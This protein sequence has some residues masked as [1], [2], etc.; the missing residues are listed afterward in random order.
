MK[1]KL[2]GVAALAVLGA[3]SWSCTH[4]PVSPETAA[5]ANSREVAA[6]PAC[7]VPKDDGRAN[8]APCLTSPALK[9]ADP[10]PQLSLA[11]ISNGPETDG[12]DL[13]AN[14]EVY[15]FFR[16]HPKSETSPKFRCFRTTERNFASGGPAEFYNKKGVIVPAAVAVGAEGSANDGVLLDAS[17]R[18]VLDAR[19]KA[20]EG[21]E[22]KVKYFTGGTQQGRHFV[23]AGQISEARESEGFTEV[24][25][26]RVFWALGLPV[27]R[28]YNV[29]KVHCFGCGADPFNQKSAQAGATADFTDAAIELKFPGKTIAKTWPWR[30]VVDTYSRSWPLQARLDF[31]ALVLAAQ[32]ISYHNDLD[33]QNRVGCEQGQMADGTRVC[34]VPVALINDVGSTFGGPGGGFLFFGPGNSRGDL[35]DYTKAHRSPGRV[36]SNPG[37]CELIYPLGG[38]KRVSRAGVEAFKHRLAGFNQD[39]ARAIFTAAKFD[40]VQPGV[41]SQMGSR[42]AVIEAW[43]AEFMKRVDEIRA[44]QCP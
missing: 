22:L 28:M 44:A 24:A 17:G 26:S 15:C 25:A 43:T 21:L 14:A 16:P 2:A 33:K 18:P 6:Q 9:W 3:L 31:E 38:L 32:L 8:L 1:M 34:A 37:K 35:S 12:V 41:L 27:D 10:A 7:V 23:G 40:R 11:Q 36:F 5:V 4:Q 42:E 13:S 19:G 39:F 30:T 29:A 20:E